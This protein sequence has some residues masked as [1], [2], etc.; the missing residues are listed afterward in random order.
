MNTSNFHKIQEFHRV[1]DHPVNTTP[2]HDLLEDE[3]LMQLRKDLIAEEFE[4]FQE[5]IRDRSLP[6]VADA[7]GDLLYVVYGAAAVLGI[8]A[9]KVFDQVHTSNM[10]KL[11][12]TEE[13]AVSTVKHY[14]EVYERDVDYK[15]SMNGKWVVFDKNSGKI[16]KSV[17]FKTP[18]FDYLENNEKSND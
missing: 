10:S 1:F 6:D 17:S 11:C 8:D 7:I 14:K 9:D 13:D 4:E 5:A 16:L 15:P 12:A 18:C 3:S 2:R